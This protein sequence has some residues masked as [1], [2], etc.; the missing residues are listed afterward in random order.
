MSFS[1]R[2]LQMHGRDNHFERKDILGIKGQDHREGEKERGNPE[3]LRFA[4]V[5]I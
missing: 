2:S 3:A 4:R 5:L 1:S